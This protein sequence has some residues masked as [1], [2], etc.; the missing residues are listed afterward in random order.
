VAQRGRVACA[1]SECIGREGRSEG[2]VAHGHEQ[3]EPVQARAMCVAEG[4]AQHAFFVAGSQGDRSAQ[5]DLPQR[6]GAVRFWGV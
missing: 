5:V 4:S 1:G 6:C 2:M 3:R